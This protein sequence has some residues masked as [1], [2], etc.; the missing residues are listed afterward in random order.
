[1]MTRADNTMTKEEL[2]MLRQD[3]LEKKWKVLDEMVEMK[4]E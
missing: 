2:M 1:M 3:Y 4:V